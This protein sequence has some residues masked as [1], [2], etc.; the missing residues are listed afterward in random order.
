[1]VK[2]PAANS[3]TR[4]QSHK[5]ETFEDEKQQADEAR[6][7]MVEDVERLDREGAAA[8]VRPVPKRYKNFKARKEAGAYQNYFEGLAGQTAESCN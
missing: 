8:M 1:M 5:E 4:A 6:R 7:L 3:Q 2:S